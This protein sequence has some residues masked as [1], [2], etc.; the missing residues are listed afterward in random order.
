MVDT[1]QF[2]VEPTPHTTLLYEQMMFTQR[3]GNIFFP[4][5]LL[6]TA[7]TTLTEQISYSLNN[8]LRQFRGQSPIFSTGARYVL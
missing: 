4:R 3:L 1:R 2:R 6:W 8:G 5:Q 7:I